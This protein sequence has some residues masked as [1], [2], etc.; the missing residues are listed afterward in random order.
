[1]IGEQV[2]IL[3]NFIRRKR[4]KGMIYPGM[5]V[6]YE[7]AKLISERKS[8]WMVEYLRARRTRVDCS[9]PLHIRNAVTISYY[10]KQHFFS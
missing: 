3:V 6:S 4:F 10:R 9:K 7:D 2:S 1:M 5:A 8:I